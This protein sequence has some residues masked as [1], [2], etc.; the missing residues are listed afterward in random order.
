M[1]IGI[2][3]ACWTNHRGYGRYTRNLLAALL[4][5]GDQHTYVG[6]ADHAT[7]AAGGFPPGLHLVPVRLSESPTVAA[8]ASG[9]RKVTDM[10]RLSRAV[11]REGVDLLFFPSSYSFFPVLGRT[12]CVVVVHDAIAERHP[13]LI[14]PTLAGRA[15]WTLKTRVACWQAD[16]V[17]TVSRDAARAVRR[18]LRVPAQRL[19]VVAEAADPHFGPGDGA[20]AAAHAARARA[21]LPE[22]PFFMFVGGFAPHKNLGALLT[23]FAWLLAHRPADQPRPHLAL[24]GKT[25]GDAFHSCYAALRRQVVDLGLESD[26]TFPGYVPDADLVHLYRAATAVVL[27]SR[28]EGFGLPVAEAMACG[29]PVVTSRGGALPEL[30]GDAGLL[31]DPD[32]AAAFAAALQ[33]LL[34]QPDLA[35]DLGA[36][37]LRRTQQLSWGRAAADLRRIFAEL[38]PAG[39]TLAAPA[40]EGRNVYV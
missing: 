7:L 11:W 29:T 14:F 28:D 1:R 23:A 21:G 34:D 17:V 12:R 4:A 20:S 33:R 31:V 5:E 19:R 9:R 26:V 22:R 18:H 15:A 3:L 39:V 25:E 27:P 35:A 38:D 2:D 8:S 36:R 13:D 24:V 37:G 16:R 32:Q 6:F 10:L 30:V 40:A